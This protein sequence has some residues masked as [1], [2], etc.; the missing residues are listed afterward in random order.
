MQ[1]HTPV[2]DETRS[3]SYEMTIFD[4]LQQMLGQGVHCV[5]QLPVSS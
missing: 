4:A 3:T 1:D 5:F 2:V